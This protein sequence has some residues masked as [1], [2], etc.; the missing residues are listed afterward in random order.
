MF[1]GLTERLATGLAVAALCGGAAHAGADRLYYERSLMLAADA[2][3]GLFEPQVRA[4][5]D[6]SAHQARGAALRAGATSDELANTGARAVLRARTADCASDDL[7][8]AAARVRDGFAGWRRTARM[9]FPGERQDWSADRT[10][11]GRDAWRLSQT[12]RFRSAPV[13]FGR[14]TDAGGEEGLAAVVSF[15]GRP[16]PYGARIVLRDPDRAHRPWIIQ[17]SVG[18]LPPA[19]T[20]RAF[21]AASHEAAPGILLPEGRRQGEIWRFP[22]AAGDAIAG[23]DPRERFTVEFLFRDDSVM[24]VHFEAGDFAAARA[25]LSLG[26]L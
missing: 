11:Y 10:R 19:N 16:R 24:R 20:R 5:L 15:P 7:T 13:T 6:V 14:V 4:A 26:P 12:G 2:R 22:E 1:K 23:L 9:T 18:L 17:A 25:F 3:C 8:T 21:W